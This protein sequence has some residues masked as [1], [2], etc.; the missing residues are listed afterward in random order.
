MM[1]AVAGLAVV[2]AGLATHH[3][4]LGCGQTRLPLS[5]QIVD[6]HDGRP[7]V[8]AKFELISDLGRPAD[9]SEIT[10]KNGE[11]ETI[12]EAGTTTFH[13]PFFRRYRVIYVA[14][15][16]VRI[17]TEGYERVEEMLR[18]YMKDPAYHSDRTSYPPI[19]VRLKRKVGAD[20]GKPE[21]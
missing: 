3:S 10:G 11:V 20:S 13:G 21:V 5:F 18:E 4:K 17:Q 8:G 15:Y 2:L 16:A 6:D 19:I 7:V 9:V 1:F 14:S 12:V